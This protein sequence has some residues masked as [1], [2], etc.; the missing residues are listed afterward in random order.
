MGSAASVTV[1]AA[2]THFDDL[3]ESSGDGTIFRNERDAASQQGFGTA[4]IRRFFLFPPPDMALCIETLI[5]T[6]GGVFNT[7][8]RINGGFEFLS[9]LSFLSFLRGFTLR[10]GFG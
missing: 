5:E 10:V 1:R 3:K 8:I 6:P 7:Y 2:G 9:F 4:R